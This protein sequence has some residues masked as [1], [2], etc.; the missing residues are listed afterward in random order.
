MGKIHSNQ[1]GFSAVEAVIILIVLVILAG[2]GYMV[3][4]RQHNKKDDTNKSTTSNSQTKKDTS[5]DTT[6]TKSTVAKITELGVQFTL[7][8]DLSDFTYEVKDRTTDSGTYKTAY[9]GTKALEALGCKTVSADGTAPALE[10]LYKGNGQYP[11]SPS[12][13]NAPGKLV[14]QFSDF[15]IASANRSSACFPNESDAAKN[16]T[17]TDTRVKLD[18]ALQSLELIKAY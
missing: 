8:S 16:Q 3:Y 9:T 7:P 11:A 2:A 13:N 5:D 4:N 10:Y 14:K 12:T 18:Q 15:Y 1:K 17:V 6:A